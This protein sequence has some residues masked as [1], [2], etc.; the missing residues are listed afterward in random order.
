MY[1]IFKK[2]LF[3]LLFLSLLGCGQANENTP[4]PSP[5][6]T[7]RPGW[8]KVSSEGFQMFLPES[9]IIG[10]SVD[11]DSIINSIRKMG[12]QFEDAANVLNQNRGAIITFAVDKRTGDS[13][14]VTQIVVGKIS[15]PSDESVD[16]YMNALVDNLPDQIQVS[17]SEVFTDRNYPM[18]QLISEVNSPQTGNIKQVTYGI[19]NG[20]AIWQIVFATPSDEYELRL[21]EFEQIV[22][23]VIVPFSQD[24]TNNQSGNSTS[25]VIGVV[26]VVAS[27]ILNTLYRKR[28]K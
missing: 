17:H 26:L 7:A 23:T 8:Q 19:K 27:L 9:Y 24:K 10:T 28:R 11:F 12:P 1:T 15:W 16:S 3:I 2:V 6:V 14:T 21:S 20:G 5:V 25:V 18:F 22:E 13:G 4:I